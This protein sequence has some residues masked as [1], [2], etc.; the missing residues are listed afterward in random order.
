MRRNWPRMISSASFS[1][2]GILNPKSLSAAL[3]MMLGSLLTPTVNVL[4]TLILIFCRE[5]APFKSMLIGIGLRE[6]YA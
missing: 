2:S 1:I 4:G 5:S 3:A 6:M